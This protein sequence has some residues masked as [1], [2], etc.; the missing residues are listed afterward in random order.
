MPAKDV[1]VQE[2]PTERQQILPINRTMSVVQTVFG[3]VAMMDVET[4]R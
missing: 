1:L 2:V 4:S 3:A